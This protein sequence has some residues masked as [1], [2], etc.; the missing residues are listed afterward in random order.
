MMKENGAIFDKKPIIFDKIFIKEFRSVKVLFLSLI[1]KHHFNILN[2]QL[3]LIKFI[4]N[5]I[6]F[7]KMFLHNTSIRFLFL[8]ICFK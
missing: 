3:V 2:I 6:N 4:I 7:Y 5:N 8:I 1:L